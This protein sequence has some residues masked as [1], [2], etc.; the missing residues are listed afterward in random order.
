MDKHI[1]LSL[2]TP[3]PSPPHKLTVNDL[4]APA[5]IPHV[6]LDNPNQ[7]NFSLAGNH[8]SPQKRQRTYTHTGAV[9]AKRNRVQNKYPIEDS[10][11]IPDNVTQSD[12]LNCDDQ[13]NSLDLG[14]VSMETSGQNI[15]LSLAQQSFNEYTDAVS[16]Q[17]IGFYCLTYD[18]FIVQGWDY[19]NYMSTVCSFIYSLVDGIIIYVYM[20]LDIL[21]SSSSSYFRKRQ[22]YCVLLPPRKPEMY[23][24]AIPGNMWTRSF[25]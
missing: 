19:R 16:A 1:I 21:V 5:N 11:A 4:H 2:D 7:L 14:P 15:D 3:P 23:T 13:D 6:I 25:P 12:V 24:C 20:F 22:S 9:H 18:L 8:I 17:S 10:I